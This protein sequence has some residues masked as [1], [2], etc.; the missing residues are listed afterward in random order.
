MISREDTV[1]DE[2]VRSA[3]LETAV[4]ERRAVRRFSAEVVDGETIEGL[5]A[6]AV[7]APSALNAQHWAFAVFQGAHLLEDF[8]NRARRHLETAAAHP[9]H[10]E[11]HAHLAMRSTD[12]FH[13]AST[14]IVI[15]ATSP[16]PQAAEDC[17]LAAQNL[18]LVAHGRGLGS[19]PIGS[20]RSW[21]NLPETRAVLDFGDAIPVFPLVLGYPAERPPRPNR[22]TPR[23]LTWR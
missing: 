10:P 16:E 20:V 18:L 3:D 7:M 22:R 12:L 13:G 2:L 1:L 19:C 6:A 9:L 8:S 23:I 5:L 14:L 21:L 11:A 15:C 4:L 17:C